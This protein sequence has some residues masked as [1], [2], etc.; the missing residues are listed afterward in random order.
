MDQ[1]RITAQS[2]NERRLSEALR[3]VR[4]VTA[5]TTDDDKGRVALYLDSI[6]VEMERINR[7]R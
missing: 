2:E 6:D 1:H 4:E 7:T 3:T 5:A